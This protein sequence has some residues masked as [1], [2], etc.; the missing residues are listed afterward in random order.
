[1]FV[2]KIYNIKSIKKFL[3]KYKST[4]LLIII[5]VITSF[6]LLITNSKFQTTLANKLADEINV[7]FGTEIA[8]NKATLSYNGR[9]I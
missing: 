7:E 5:L 9:W 3:K 1:L 2:T 4:L 6:I 8:I